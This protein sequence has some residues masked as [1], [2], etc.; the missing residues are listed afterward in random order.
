MERWLRM[1]L[2]VALLISGLGWK[3][4]EANASDAYDDLRSKW[5]FMLTGGSTYDQNDSAINAAIQRITTSAQSAWNTMSPSMGSSDPWNSTTNSAAIVQG[6]G[7]IYQMALAYRT[8][9]ST[10]EGNSQLLSAIKTALDWMY[11]NRY[12]TSGGYGNW[13][14]WEIGA[15]N[16][17]L[18]IVTLLYDELTSVQITNWM[19]VVEYYSPVAGQLHN[20]TTPAVATG[21]NLAWKA[22]IVALR[23]ILVKDSAKLLGARNALSP[24]F[25]YVTD[26]DGFYIDG[27][28]IQH[29]AQP[30]NGGYGVALMMSIGDLVQLLN[31]SIWAVSDPNLSRMY[32]WVF[33]AFEPLLYNGKMMDMVRG[34]EISRAVNASGRNAISAL[35]RISQF[36]PTVER[37]AIRSIVKSVM[38]T[39]TSSDYYLASSIE[40]I[41]LA[42]EI[43]QN[44]SPRGDLYLN[45][46]YPGMDKAVHLRPGFG[47]GLSMYSSRVMNYEK[48]NNENLHGWHTAEGMTYLYNGDWSQYADYWPTVDAFKLPGTTVER[49][50]TQAAKQYNTKGWVGGVA[51]GDTYGVSGMSIKT[52]D[53]TLEAKKSWF[54]LDNE[55]VALGAG[56]SS[57]DS[58]VVETIVENRKL[59]D[60]GNNAFMINGSNQSTSL[61]QGYQ[62]HTNTSWMHLAG[63]GSG[64]DIGYYFP[65]SPTLR[66]MREARTGAYSDIS[67]TGSTT[68]ITKNYLTMWLDHGIVP[69]NASYQYVLLPGYTSSQVSAYASNPDIQVLSNNAN[70]QAVREK[71]IGIVGANFWENA[72]E[73]VAV[74]G[75][76]Y[77]TSNKKS[78]VMVKETPT[79]AVIAISDP[80]QVLNGEIEVELYRN[81]SLVLENDS[82]IV[83]DQLSPS[84]KLRVNVTG[85]NGKGFEARIKLANR[86]YW[87]FDENSGSTAADSTGNGHTGTLYNASFTSG[88]FAGGAL[89]L[90]G[91]SSY[92]SVPDAAE[93]DFTNKF[94]LDTWIRFSTGA[95]TT[96]Q[97]IIEKQGATLPYSVRISNAGKIG[98]YWNGTW[99][100]SNAISWNNN[101]WY[102]LVITHNGSAIDFQLDGASRGVVSNT[103]ST[104]T[105]NENFYIGRGR[106]GTE[107]WFNGQIDELKLILP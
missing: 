5:T 31:G 49:N 71:N 11:T 59:N 72:V 99:R 66:T 54:M 97:K 75:E 40:M 50:T 29:T 56:I 70:V 30:Y 26:G 74:N 77:L 61:T 87:K 67:Q 44:A 92:V 14:D 15:P 58:P 105:N 104:F 73:T 62:V 13:W 78:S 90:N 64:A 8:E 65:T 34:R 28:F 79:E 68:P 101:T 103:E 2:V 69:S 32:E 47:F 86:A 19:N 107:S 22:R 38:D 21:A 51:V 53:K 17:L 6:Y 102:H 37:N 80:T 85:A 98:L 23:G 4:E 84:I 41:E 57:S 25:L 24:L 7:L 76:P 27:S 95:G 55:I 43:L 45:K 60:S 39:N 18:N 48:T 42:R 100:E 94:K 83:V 12:N 106:A 3:G 63:T 33:S 96:T 82:G 1:I 91:T 89:S 9:G 46:Q 16:H 36:A 88:G 93:L 35:I 81:G 52:Q 20:A 10:L